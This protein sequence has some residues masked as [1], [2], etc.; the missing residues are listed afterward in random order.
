MSISN[1][2]TGIDDNPLYWKNKPKPRLHADKNLLKCDYNDE[3]SQ[4]WEEDE[5]DEDIVAGIYIFKSN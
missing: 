5:Y 3:E 1:T 4:E 2:E